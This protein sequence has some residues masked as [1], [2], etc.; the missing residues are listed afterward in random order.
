MWTMNAGWLIAAIQFER[1][2]TI[3]LRALLAVYGSMIDGNLY[4][5]KAMMETNLVKLVGHTSLF[6]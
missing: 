6:R 2:N 4:Y 3:K 5:A 1:A